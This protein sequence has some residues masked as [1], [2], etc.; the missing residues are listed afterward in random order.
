VSA[1]TRKGRLPDNAEA[2]GFAPH[3][4]PGFTPGL[5]ATA[6]IVRRHDRD[7][8]QT[9]LFAPGDRREA[10][11]A[12]Y[13]FNFEVARV[14]EV[15]TNPMLGR[16]RLQW[17]REVVDAAY[18]GAPAR[19]HEVVRPLAVVI[20][21]FGLSRAY[22]D[23][24]ID[25][26]E[27]DLDDA[28]PAD[29]AA[30]VDYAEG[31]SSALLWAALEALGAAEPAT[32]AGAREVGIAYAMAGLLR[33]MPFHA[34]SRRCYIPEEIAER[35]GI[36]PGAYARRRDTPAL[37]SAVAELAEAAA[38]HLIAAR[39]LVGRTPRRA[40]AA[41]LPAVIADRFLRSLKRAGYNPFAPE[42]A[43][44]DP[45]QSWRLALVALR[46]RF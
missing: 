32:L 34:A 36:D 30:L 21:E 45:L 35:V 2:T 12:L 43:A 7:R 19:R 15:V 37:R 41:L 46:G 13:A 9:V 17:W 26:R 27:R 38:G 4:A 16:I 22:L 24:I 33:A 39:Q 25:T 18:A 8:Y 29:M 31:T 20:R 1:K 5:S 42:L 10:L 40:M 44:P 11:F 23:R 14:R 28:L 3:F 6:A